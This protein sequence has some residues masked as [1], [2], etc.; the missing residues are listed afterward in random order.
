MFSVIN[1]WFLFLRSSWNA[2]G[3]MDKDTAQQL[4]IDTLLSLAENFPPS[5]KRDTL[6]QTL[7]V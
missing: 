4:Y 6:I 3:D 1:C 2:L 7:Y 5:E